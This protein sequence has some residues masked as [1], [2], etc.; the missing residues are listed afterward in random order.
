MDAERGLG[1]MSMRLE[2]YLNSLKGKRVAVVGVG[3]SNTPLLRLLS[4][5]GI[6]VT[7]CDQK[8]EAEFGPLATELREMGVCLS[9]GE[10]YLEGLNQDVIFRSPGI[11]PDIS[12]FQTAVEA[13]SVLTS[14]MEVFFQVCPCRI[15]GVTGS[16]GKTTTTTLI[17]Q[18][19]SNAG[20]TVHIGGN[21]GR[22]L[23]ADV[24]QMQPEDIAVLELSS[25]QLMTL[26]QSPH[27][28][29]MTNLSPNHLDIH[30]SMEEYREAKENI[31]LYQSD[32]DLAVF[33]L[34]NEETRILSQKAKGNLRLFSRQGPVSSGA[35]VEDG[36]IF[37][38]DEN[39]TQTL[40]QTKDILIPGVHNVENYL[41]AIAAVKDLVSPAVMEET[42]RTFRGVE[43][44]I[45]LV[46]TVDGVRYYNDSIASSPTRTIAGLRAFSEQVIL[47]AGGY[48]KKI[49]FDE[50][51]EEICLRVKTL[52][53]NGATAPN[54]QQAVL[55]ANNYREGFP[56]IILAENFEDAVL[57]AR[58][59]AREKDIVLMSPACASFDQFPNFAARGN[60]F[61][62]YVKS[63]F[64]LGRSLVELSAAIQGPSAFEQSVALRAVSL[65]KEFMPEAYVDRYGNAVG[66][67]RCGKPNA[68][69]LLLDA[70][71]D[72]I[73]LIITGMESGFLRFRSIGGVDPRIL[74]N[75]RVQLL[76]K[77]PLQGVIT[78][79][80]PHIQTAGEQ[81]TG[82]AIEDLWI[83]LGLSQ[84]EAER[85]VP[86]GT[87]VVFASEAQALLGG[88]LSG[89][90]LDDR[91]GF[92]ALL[93]AAR[94]LKDADLDVDIYF[95][96]STRE[97]VSGSGA[98]VAAFALKPDC[99]I[100]VDVTHGRTPDAPK[101]D[102]FLLGKGPVIGI[103]PNMTKWVTD[104]LIR[105]A[106]KL[107]LPW[108]P[109]VMGGHSGTNAWRLQISREGV[110]TGLL[111]IPL[112]YMHTAHEVVKESDIA[113]TGALLAAFVQNLGKEGVWE[114]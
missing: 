90:A 38:A 40:F 78:C 54:I 71:L 55:T 70:H 109:E 42:A 10:N 57:T 88:Q 75:Q 29:V 69:S 39:G 48:D 46:D 85:L 24:E 35:Y 106:E 98:A 60:R 76:T 110:P 83:D 8:T 100:A 51:G 45:E 2:D 91:A 84:E 53:L 5:A 7:A 105:T 68:K 23:L 21:I 56:Q 36:T 17:A 72:E 3:I 79:L 59:I 11:R 101:E 74:P 27:I 9:F 65:L 61:K 81:N 47:I 4:G 67:R 99:C 34:D 18:M 62:D 20:Y 111:S 49:P 77:Q 43:H 12:A 32:D 15:I 80:P 50:L 63:F 22:P 103:G 25:F 97:E 89:K 19:L 108:Q 44:R 104:G 13:G 41:A 87:P 31:F 114:Q 95:L 58:R 102:T 82:T 86:V 112:K 14:E 93:E 30:T 66:L 28:C 33:N 37:F 107:E 52:I 113:Q 64:E 92:V 16:D 6:S 94:R 1:L 73:G 26:R 96:G